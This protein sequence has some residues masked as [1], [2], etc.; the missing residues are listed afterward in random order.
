MYNPQKP[1]N[2]GLHIYVIADSAK[3]YVFSLIYY[4]GSTTKESSM[5]PEL[6]FTSRIVLLV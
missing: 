5:H 4:F 6:I 3:G 2:W 1:T